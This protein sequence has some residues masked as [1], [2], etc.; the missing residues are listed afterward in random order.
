MSGEGGE[1]EGNEAYLPRENYEKDE[2][3]NDNEVLRQ[4][5]SE[6]WIKVKAS[7]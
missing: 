5:L 1:Y 3:F 6:L 4:M 2:V 7:Q